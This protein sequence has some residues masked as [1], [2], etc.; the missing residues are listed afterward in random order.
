MTPCTL[1][2]INYCHYR[3]N[4]LLSE[5]QKMRGSLYLHEGAVPK[6]H[7]SSD[8]R[9][10]V[11]A[12]H[13]AWHILS[14]DNSGQVNGCARYVAH[15]NTVSYSDLGLT[16]SSIATS[17]DWGGT[18]RAAVEA[19]IQ[20]AQKQNLAF[21]EVGGW[22]IAPRLQNTSEA[23]RIALASYALARILNG[24]IGVGTVTQRHLSSS[25]LRRVGGRSLTWQ[26]VELPSYFDPRYGCQME[27][28]RFASAEPNPRFEVWIDELHQ[29]L[30]TAE[31]VVSSD[32]L[33]NL[34]RALNS[35]AYSDM[36]QNFAPNN[37]LQLR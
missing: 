23:I 27:I 12:D 2:G 20:F 11:P 29:Y 15:E 37:P 6:R 21:V 7:L 22:A 24:C 31:V 26:G 9:H 17:Q 28:L 1:L 33:Q 4:Y 5:M 3:H 32:S 18:L 10:C 13:Q 34:Q 25:I 35:Y 16:D 8:G 36:N 19:E 14:I 30:L